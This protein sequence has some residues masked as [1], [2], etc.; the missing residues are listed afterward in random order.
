MKRRGSI[1]LARCL[2]NH[3]SYVGQTI[4]EPNERIRQHKKDADNGRSNAFHNAIR[5]HGFDNFVWCWLHWKNI[6]E[7]NLDCYERYYIWL[8]DLQNKINGYNITPGG[9]FQSV[10]I[11]EIVRKQQ[12][13]MKDPDIRSKWIFAIRESVNK[14]G[15]QEG[16]ASKIRGDNNPLR[17]NPEAIKNHLD[18][19]TSQENRDKMS[20]S[21]KNLW[22]DPKYRE[23]QL[24][25][26]SINRLQKEKE[27]GQ[28]LL[29]EDEE[30][31][32]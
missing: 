20:K 15:V 25:T 4:Q 17:N 2:I 10:K 28:F 19:V 23:G 30:A 8:Y 9:D 3:K 29:F 16:R 27:N 32:E 21:V 1:Y 26:R 18:A 6:P 22:K 11:P 12:E 7:E 31:D 13:T 24:M 14:P 5:K